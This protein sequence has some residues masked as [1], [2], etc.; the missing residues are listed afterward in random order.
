MQDK[1][2]NFS[3]IAHIDHGKST[4]SNYLIEFCMGEKIKNNN[5]ILDNMELEKERGITIK[6]KSITLNYCA[7]NKK[8]Y[9]INFID[10]P[11]HVDFSYE[12]S[13]SLA[14]CEGALL[15]VDSTQGIEAQ[16]IVNCKNAIK[17]G[18]KIIPIISKIDLINANPKMVSYEL[19]ETFGIKKEDIIYCSAKKKIGARNILEKIVNYIPSPKGKLNDRLQA[20]IIDSWFDN[21]LGIISLICIKSGVISQGDIVK[22]MSTNQYYK[23]EK[24]GVFNPFSKEKIKLI[25]GEIGWISCGIKNI[26]ASPVGDTI[27]TLKDSAKFPI[28]GFKKIKPQIYAGIFSE[29][30][31]E[32]LNLNKAIRK[33]GLNDASLFYEKESSESL[34]L[35]FRCGFLGLL[36]MDIVKERLIRE[37]NLKLIITPP[38][39]RYKIIKS[40]K[41]VIYLDNPCDIL[42]I[43][44]KFRI[45]E[46]IAACKIVIP[47]NYLGKVIKL[48]KEYRGEQENILYY[49][50]QVIL[51][52]FIP[53]NEILFDFFDRLQ[54]ISKGYAS[55]DYKFKNF[56]SSNLSVVE[57]KINGEK[58]EY[59]T[60]IVH[61]NSVITYSKNIIQKVKQSISRHQF[62]IN[63]QACIGN[64]II[65]SERIK[66]FRKNV[67]AKCY[68][69]DV[70]RKKKLLNKQ[71]IGKKIMKNKGKLKLNRE[72]FLKILHRNF[73]S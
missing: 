12:V 2:R 3:I 63:I 27:T 31:D 49:E 25:S 59:L 60:N 55:L 22:I 62:N 70:N 43:K 7:L 72:F 58:I 6:A 29:K 46:P 35:G 71:K 30:I 17:M 20:L 47:I 54:S 5:Q 69:G 65:T 28:S 33:L 24:L 13:R 11:G 26:H 4:L 32:H 52:Y 19:K 48:C 15:V 56:K 40:N 66:Q 45:E 41:Q 50:K 57:I 42:K 8:D 67:I 14:A 1:I 44:D 37:Y 68:G 23:V 61:K 10:T 21:Y 39:V 18:L 38:T 36:H 53:I 9:R 73:N 34:G 64:R 51:K 16:T